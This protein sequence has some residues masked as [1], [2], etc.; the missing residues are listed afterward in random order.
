M[1][2]DGGVEDAI[3]V[4]IEVLNTV[5]LHEPLEKVTR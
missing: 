5:V 3:G 2:E 1:D 4:E